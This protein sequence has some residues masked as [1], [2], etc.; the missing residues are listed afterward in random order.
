LSRYFD[1][2][3]CRGPV[4]AG[5]RQADDIHAQLAQQVAAR[6]LGAVVTLDRQSCFG[7][8]FFGPN[9]H[10]RER[11]PAAPAGKPADEIDPTAPGTGAV[12]GRVSAF[13][14]GV[15]ADDADEILA[16]HVLAGR[17]VERLVRR[18]PPPSPAE[19]PPGSQ[20]DVR[21][22]TALAHA[23]ATPGPPKDPEPSADVAPD[24]R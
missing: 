7:R 15:R 11:V 22:A 18:V 5:Q 1:I 3:V 13:Y 16:T 21:L 8:C 2:R 24:P 20:P 19:V 10:V 12:P 23:D 14:S 17:V 9:V 4:C 6:D